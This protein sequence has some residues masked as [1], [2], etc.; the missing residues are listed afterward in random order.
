MNQ[1]NNMTT[2]ELRQK[3]IALVAS[4]TDEQAD[5]AF[6]VLTLGDEATKALLASGCR[7]Y[8]KVL[9]FVDEWEKGAR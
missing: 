6:R 8:N 5:L 9:A 4:M 1:P 7:G 2:E 3:A